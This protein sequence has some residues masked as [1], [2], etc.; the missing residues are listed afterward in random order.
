MA[1]RD[2]GSVAPGRDLVEIVIEDDGAG[3]TADVL[4]W[5][6]EPFFT[7]KPHGSG[8]GLG[9]AMVYG[10]VRNHGGQIM[11]ESRPGAGTKATIQLPARGR[12]AV[13]RRPSVRPDRDDLTGITVLIV[14]DEPLL[15]SASDRLLTRLGATV[16]QAGDGQQALA[17]LERQRD[18]I[19]VVILDLNMPVMDGVRTFAEIR[20]RS[21]TLPILISTGYG[22][23][24]ERVSDLLGRG[25]CRLVTK[26][27]G[28]SGVSGA[29]LG[30][31]GESRAG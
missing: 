23:D 29:I 21:P 2:A 11:I 31:L 14:D 24:E 9:L 10:T 28:I 16:L 7:T 19:D 15:R 27:H 20:K 18:A 22:E 3:M 25:R 1:A 5:C 12:G 17:I 4:E 8:S 26:P 13:E 30:L 6:M